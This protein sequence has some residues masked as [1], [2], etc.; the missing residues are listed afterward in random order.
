MY[1]LWTLGIAVNYNS[2]FQ[3]MPFP[4][5]LFITGGGFRGSYGASSSVLLSLLGITDLSTLSRRRRQTTNDTTD[6]SSVEL[7]GT[8]FEG[9]D[10][11]ITC[12]EL[13]DTM[14]FTITNE[15]YPVYD[16]DSLLNTN[17][18]FDYG[19]FRQLVESQQT[20]GSAS[21]FAYR[22]RSSGVYVFELSNNPNRKIVCSVCVMYSQTLFMCAEY[23]LINVGREDYSFS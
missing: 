21:L 4:C 11:P 12:L 22:F 9:I 2:C 1:I 18:A 20:S 15:S 16:E 10:D 17:D 19:Q 5:V 3:L 8:T 14:L 23:L 6:D 13:G 7:N